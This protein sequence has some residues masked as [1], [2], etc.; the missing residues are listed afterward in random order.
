MLNPIKRIVQFNQ[1]SSRNWG[2]YNGNYSNSSNVFP[3]SSVITAKQSNSFYNYGS[4]GMAN[5]ISTPDGY[6]TTTNS[7][8]SSDAFI[9]KFTDQNTK[10][11]GTYYGGELEE[12]DIDFHPYDNGNKFYIVGTTQSLT[13]IAST[14]GLQQTKQIFDTVNF[15]QQSAYNIFIAHFEPN[16]LSNESFIANNS[17]IIYPNP[18]NDYIKIENNKT[19]TENFNYKI[20]DVTGRIVKNDTSRFNENINIENFSDGIYTIKIETENGEKTS[21]KL[22]KN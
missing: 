22:I 12:R 13:Q 21:K 9:C 5:N 18:A 20:I 16:P 8:Y 2:T 7:I 17:I 3:F 10:S 14:N 4:T 11:W 1:D 15:T 19:T 6:L